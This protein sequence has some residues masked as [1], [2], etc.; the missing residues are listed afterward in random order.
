[1]RK[2]VVVTGL[3]IV[4]AVGVRI[5]E[6]WNALVEGRDGTKAITVF[7]ASPYRTKIAAEV[8]PFNP[9]DHFSKKEIRRLSRC[10]QFGLVAFR[11]AWKSAHLDQEPMDRERAGVILGAGSG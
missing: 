6:F 1:M 9:G 4:S 3:G 2:R 5:P 8:S 7:D 10:D 11:E